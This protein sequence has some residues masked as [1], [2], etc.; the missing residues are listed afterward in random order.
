VRS[1]AEAAL[2]SGDF[3]AAQKLYDNALAVRRQAFG[4][5]SAAYAAALVEAA[6][7]YQVNGKRSAQAMN[8]YREALPIQEATLGA[9]HPDVATTLFYLAMGMPYEGP[10]KEEAIQMYQRAAN[11]RGKAFGPSDPR[12]AEILT[13]LA[14]LTADEPMFQQSLGILNAS[15]G[16]SSLLASTLELYS[17]FLRGRERAAEAE[18]MEARAKDIRIARVA[19]IGRRR[20]S[21]TASTSALR[22][23]GGVTPPKLK[24]KVEPE[25]TDT[26][27]SAKFQGMVVLTMEVGTDGLASNIQLKRGIGLGLDEKAAEAIKRWTF[28]PGTKDGQPVT[29][30]ARVEVNFRLM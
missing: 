30:M 22:V 3:D 8:L 11:I 5:N 28:V 14:R 24:S 1:R 18:P 17:Q 12:L 2:R 21:R 9:D 6:R 10:R 13:P 4:E 23:G 20:D 25:Y 19:E 29:V 26:A 7:A 16:E 15:A 27:R